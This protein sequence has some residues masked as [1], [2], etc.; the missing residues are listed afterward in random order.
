MNYKVLICAFAC[1]KDP[2]RRFG[3]GNGGEGVLGKNIVVQLGKFC[4]IFVITHISNK[5][6]I[7][8]EKE[9]SGKRFYYV[10]LPEF[11]NFTKKVVQVYAYLWQIKAY[12]V[13]KKLNK[14]IHF[15]LFHH[16]TYANDWMASYMGALLGVPYVRGPG[17]GAHRIPRNFVNSFSAKDRVKEKIRSFGQWMYRHD[18][19]FV[20]GQKKAKAILVCNQEAINAIP[21]KWQDKVFL[22]SVNGI[23]EKDLSITKEY[24][25][26]TNRDFTI[27]TAGKLIKLK[28]FDLA[29]KAFKIF[30]DKVSNAKFTIIGEG[31]EQE[32][33]AKLVAELRLDGKVIFEPWVPREK[34]LH[35][36]V[37]CDTFLFPSLR[38]GGGNVVVEAMA[39]GVP[40]VCFN[41]AGPGFHVDETCGI[42]IK[43]NNPRQAIADLA[44]ALERL[45]FD[46][47]L[48]ERLGRG[49][50]E[51]AE[52]E[53]DWNKLGDKLKEIYKKVL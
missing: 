40:V 32:S 45:Y 14:E 10:A 52:R 11:L 24:K 53:Y 19:F 46:K 20:S 33:L 23:S 44:T 36:M 5:D 31:P 12:F 28:G 16:V 37:S 15:D 48:R 47:G 27:L 49:A 21:K 2:D 7:E 18:P 41:I 17:G 39:A 1:V 26:E 42:K 34:L 9:L 3:Q 35:K 13:A 25:K 51:K 43:P 30:S 38:D 6:A 50:K 22:F 8:K 4:D 29:I